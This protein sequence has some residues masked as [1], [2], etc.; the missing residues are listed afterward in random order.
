MEDRYEVHDSIG[1]REWWCNMM[2]HMKNIHRLLHGKHKFLMRV[3][4]LAINRV[5]NNTHGTLRFCF[6]NQDQWRKKYSI[7]IIETWSEYV[8]SFFFFFQWVGQQNVHTPGIWRVNPNSSKQLINPTPTP[9]Y[10]EIA[11]WHATRGNYLAP[12]Y[13]LITNCKLRFLWEK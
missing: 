7:F 4:R 11:K 1:S 13:V 2:V 5:V 8:D 6:E 10:K 9:L 12:L 3:Q